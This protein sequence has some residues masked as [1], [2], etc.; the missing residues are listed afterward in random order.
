MIF[1]IIV[2]ILINGMMIKEDK[3]KVEKGTK[4]GRGKNIYLS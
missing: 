1:L 4:K 2:N 3:E